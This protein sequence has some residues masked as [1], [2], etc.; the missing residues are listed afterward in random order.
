M[1]VHMRKVDIFIDDKLSNC[2]EV[3]NADILTIRITNYEDEHQN[4]VN[5]KN[6]KDIYEY[7]K[8]ITID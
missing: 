1:M 5:K 7:I 8:E 3:S 6:W 2:M 4:I